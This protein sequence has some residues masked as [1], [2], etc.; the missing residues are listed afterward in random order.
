MKT[1]E[2]EVNSE[3]S[4]IKLKMTT[5]VD[6]MINGSI[7]IRNETVG[8]WSEYAFIM[9]GKP[10]PL[11]K[12]TQLALAVFESNDKNPKEF[13]FEIISRGSITAN[14]KQPQVNYWIAYD[15]INNNRK[16]N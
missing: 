4:G 7:S 2:P 13:Y 12:P 11:N 5:V 1:S 15:C 14:P 6:D 8:N 9:L 10:E 3:I 16:R